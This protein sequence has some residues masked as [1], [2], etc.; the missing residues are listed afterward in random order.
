MK[1]TLDLAIVTSCHNY[2][3]YLEEWAQSIV[4][5]DGYLPSV[6]VIVDNGSTDASPSHIQRAAAILRGAGIETITDRIPYANFGVARNRAVELSGDTEWVMHFDADDTLM[7]HAM[8]DFVELAS[9]ADVVG[10]GYRRSGDLEAGPRNKTRVYSTH[11]GES[12]L[13]STAPC[14][15]VSPFRRR[16][17]RQSPYRTDMRGGW[18]TALWLGFARLNARFVP[19]KRPVFFYRQHAGSTFN[20]RRVSERKG[21]LVGQKLNNIRNGITDGVSVVVPMMDNGNERRRAWDRVRRHYEMHHPDWQIIEGVL[22][23]GSSWCKG[24]AVRAGLEQAKHLTL[25]VADSDCIV[26]PEA[27]VKA[28]ERLSRDEV[29][30]TIPHGLVHRLDEEST[31]R[32]MQHDHWTIDNPTYE[33]APYEGFA[34]GGVVVVDRS[35]YEAIG[36]IPRAFKGWGAEDECLAV[37]LET[38]VGPHDRLGADL[39]H[40]WHPTERRSDLKNNTRNRR[41]LKL[42]IELQD[43]PDG[44]WEL[45]QG[46]AA[47]E[48]PHCV[49]VFSA[50]GENAILMHAVVT[51]QK[52]D[53]IINAGDF[54][55]VTPEDAHQY[56]SRPRKLAYPAASSTGR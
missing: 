4:G 51:H 35:E 29:G 44:M 6:C 1:K 40:L 32:M 20:Q 3:K 11:Q 2:G 13:R 24:D 15:G 21:R 50:L 12:T 54:F 5:M 10:F 36:G 33:R 52:G 39:W 25:V 46:V 7:E 42:F 38:L 30:W 14:S 53:R 17:W 48:D 22:P 28:V 19:T 26:D 55:R 37:L 49:T 23:E 45:A 43:N 18:D 9:N 41:I 56:N 47:G 16:F 34:G 8:V 27:M 31:V